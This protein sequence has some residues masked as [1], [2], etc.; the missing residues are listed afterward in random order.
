MDILL[1][2]IPY[3]TSANEIKNQFPTVI[4][5]RFLSIEF[6]SKKYLFNSAILTF[7]DNAEFSKVIDN[8]QKEHKNRYLVIKNFRKA[9]VLLGDTEYIT[10]KDIENR[11]QDMTYLFISK[12]SS[13]IKDFYVIYFRTIK[14]MNS[15]LSNNTVL[16]NGQTFYLKKYPFDDPN[17]DKSENLYSSFKRFVDITNEK[18]EDMFIIK[19]LKK[20]YCIHPFLALMI[21]GTIKRLL[22]SDNTIREFE[23][24]PIVG[25]FDAFFKV[26]QNEEVVFTD[27][28]YDPEFFFLMAAQFDI[29]FL[30][31]ETE[32]DYLFYLNPKKAVYGIKLTRKFGRGFQ[33]LAR[34][35]CTHEALFKDFIDN[36]ELLADDVQFLKDC[37]HEENHD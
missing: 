23:S 14:E 26:F 15:F 27:N 30:M 31:K 16:I 29:P 11:F 10:K 18:H 20:D 2:N 6:M 4:S 32:L 37:F 3:T 19:H 12:I 9:V 33:V 36:G 13:N 7:E 21:S 17:D 34:Y 24:E 1:E 25:D 35:F 8:I 22:M 28:E 5:Y